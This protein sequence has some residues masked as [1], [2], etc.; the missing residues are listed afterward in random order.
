M[1]SAEEARK[2]QQDAKFETN[3][4]TVASRSYY[5]RYNCCM[6]FAR[7]KGFKPNRT[8]NDHTAL[9]DYLR[10]RNHHQK[11]ANL[12][13]RR[14]GSSRLP[15]LRKLRNLADYEQDTRFTRANAQEAIDL[16]N[17]IDEWLDQVQAP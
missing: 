9:A 10:T 3:F 16:L 15:R 11:D 2:L 5:A 12:L 4:R 14:I 7:A 8:P 1:T 17:E 6:A 13:H